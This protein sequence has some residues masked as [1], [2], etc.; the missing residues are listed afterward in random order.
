MKLQ[1]L[2]LLLIPTLLGVFPHVATAQLTSE[3][4]SCETTETV[5]IFGD[6][7][8]SPSTREQV[9]TAQEQL[10][11]PI[12]S[13][14]PNLWWAKY[15]FDP[16]GGKLINNW[17]IYPQDKKVDLCVNRQLWG[18]QNYLE[19]YSFVNHFGSVVR[20]YGY[21]LQVFNQQGIRLATYECDFTSTIPQ[22][23]L[24]LQTSSSSGFQF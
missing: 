11:Q 17:L 14:Y 23:K 4:L 3:S 2:P 9:I 22:C 8:N 1:L 21:I 18:I 24:E 20:E 5:Q 19:H 10:N 16:F 15:Q 12:S 6:L 7:E 13:D